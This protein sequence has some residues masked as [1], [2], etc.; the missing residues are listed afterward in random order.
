MTGPT[1][2][3]DVAAVTPYGPWR[4]PA[5]CDI[6]LSGSEGPADAVFLARTLAAAADTGTR[7]PDGRGLTQSI[8]DR[9]GVETARI[10]VTAGADD[11]LERA[12]R[13]VLAP[14]REAIITAPT[15]EM[16]P[17]YVALT[18]ARP[19]TV[20]W[21]VTNN[22]AD[23]I[24]AA[25]TPRTA[26]IAIVTPNNPTGLTLSMDEIRRIHDGI[27]N[28][29]LLLD[30]VYIEF[31][32]IDIT[33][34]ALQLPR[35][36]IA[37]TFSKA[38]GL[39]GLRTGYAAG[40]AEIIG[41]MR[42]AGSP[43]PVAATSLAVAGAALAERDT[44]VATY[45]ESVRSMRARLTVLLE[46]CG[47]TPETSQ[48]NFV[49]VTTPRAAWL[50]DALAGLGVAVRL[51]SDDGGDRIR[52]TCPSDETTFERV[53]MALRIALKPEGILF[54]LDGV[55]ADV[56]RSY[57]VTIRE[58]AARF[59]VTLT[60]EDV[61]ARKAAGNAND[62]WALTT[63]LIQ[64]AGKNVTLAEV[65]AVFEQIYQGDGTTPGLRVTETLT[66]TRVWL[67]E[68]AQRMPLAIVTGR[69]RA[70]A[71]RFLA[72]NGIRDL[73]A[74]VIVQED[75]PLKPDPF[76]VRAAMSALGIS[77]AWMIGDTPDDVRAARAAGVLPLG[78]I[79]PEDSATVMGPALF[80]AG[81]ARIYHS[82]EEINAC[83]P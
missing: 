52:I 38:W 72:T 75:G 81:A 55:L 12:C 18:G 59:G 58:T 51:L 47:L 13:A 82:I 57:R 56:S 73:F 7:Y 62:D 28:A 65:T 42:A 30:L 25:A 69:P 5:P 40:S 46:S 26:L 11:A 21:H 24:I 1:A 79:A 44:D 39:P 68:L 29:V 76:P 43:Y 48:A 70:D 35:V 49:C 22:L 8:A 23:A 4:H 45:I 80:A 60:A 71:E 77:R 78:I 6:D 3:P 31:A 16:L 15:F 33:T 34:A 9:L 61:R 74:A 50:R 14:N 10:L 83:L 66:T 37:R 20:A 2:A 41:W 17:R 19:V 67:A 64:D 54:D 32:D 53:E 27:P 63:G 36:V